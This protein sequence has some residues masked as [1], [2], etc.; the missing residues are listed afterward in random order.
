M[1]ASCNSNPGYK[2]IVLLRLYGF[3]LQYIKAKIKA[4]TCDAF[5]DCRTHNMDRANESPWKRQ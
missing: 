2:T 3:K 5:D 1:I 4:P